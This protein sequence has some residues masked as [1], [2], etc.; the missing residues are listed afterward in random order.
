L[1]VMD[2]LLALSLFT[3]GSNPTPSTIAYVLFYFQVVND[4]CLYVFEMFHFN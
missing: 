4:Q 2:S 3:A 1:R